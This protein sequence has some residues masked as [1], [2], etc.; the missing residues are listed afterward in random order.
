MPNLN[1]TTYIDILP[2]TL[3]TAVLV[4]KL[5]F[6]ELKEKKK[7]FEQVWFGYH[8]MAEI[9]RGLWKNRLSKFPVQKQVHLE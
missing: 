3:G 7:R 4:F 6:K 5:N 8:R 9:G 2:K 1:D